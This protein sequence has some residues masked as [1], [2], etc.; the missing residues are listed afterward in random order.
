M[1]A[2]LVV[3]AAAAATPQA[4]PT[5]TPRGA[6]PAAMAIGKATARPPRGSSLG[7][8]ARGIK[9]KF[10]KGESK[11]ITDEN[12]KALS[13]GVELTT[14]APFPEPSAGDGRDRVSGDVAEARKKADWQD[15]YFSARAEAGRL[16]EEEAS[17]RQ[18]VARLEREFYARDDP[19]Q[20]D[21][22]VKPAWDRALARLREVQEALPAAR[23]APEEIADAARRDGALPGWFRE[24]PPPT[25]GPGA[26]PDRH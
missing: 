5:P 9:L 6:A 25:P 7:D 2:V 19:Y 18:E 11:V 15:R 13:G 26:G 12:L 21:S 20:R 17:L 23:R 10:P 3:L 14:G 16:E 8:V 4:T 1:I 24:A 22:V